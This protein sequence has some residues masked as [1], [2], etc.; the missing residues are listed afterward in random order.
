MLSSV[1]RWFVAKYA[2]VI[3]SQLG[4]EGLEEEP[5]LCLAGVSSRRVV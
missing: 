3:H 5:E 2:H 1:K 4:G